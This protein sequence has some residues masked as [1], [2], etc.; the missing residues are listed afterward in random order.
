MSAR[1]CGRKVQEMRRIREAG[2]GDG[3]EAGCLRCDMPVWLHAFVGARAYIRKHK[4][5]V[6]C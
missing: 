4:V 6:C 5:H 1:K 2:G 3:V